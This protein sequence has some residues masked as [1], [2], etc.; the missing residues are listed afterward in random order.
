NLLAGPLRALQHRHAASAAAGF[1]RGHQARGAGAEYD[2]IKTMLIHSMAPG[3]LLREWHRGT[4][5]V[6]RR[7]TRPSASIVIGKG[8][9]SRATF[10]GVQQAFLKRARSASMAFSLRR[11]ASV[12]PRILAAP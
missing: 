11:T 4:G 1:D 3:G 7:I 5:Q 6:F 9:R 2:D 12:S 8:A 10:A